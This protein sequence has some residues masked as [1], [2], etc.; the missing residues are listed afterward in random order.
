MAD[1]DNLVYQAKL[2]EQAERYDGKGL[3]RQGS[4]SL[5]PVFLRRGLGDDAGKEIHMDVLGERRQNGGDFSS[6]MNH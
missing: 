4:A 6:R 1:R 2:A 5:C 3:G